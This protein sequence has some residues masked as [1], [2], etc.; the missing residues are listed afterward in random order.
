MLVSLWI[1]YFYY[2]NFDYFCFLVLLFYHG[3]C[4]NCLDCFCCQYSYS[5]NIIKLYPLFALWWSFLLYYFCEMVFSYARICVIMMYIN[6]DYINNSVYLWCHTISHNT[7][8]YI[9]YETIS[10][11]WTNSSHQ[12]FFLWSY[13]SGEDAIG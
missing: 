1:R 6:S 13:R 8:Y 12:G 5:I 10:L 11:E 2:Y 9:S 7:L 3:S 4:L